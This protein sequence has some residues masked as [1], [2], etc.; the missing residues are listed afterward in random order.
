MPK[1]RKK[2]I[3]IEAVQLVEMVVIKTLEGEMVGE[4]GDWLITG[5]KGEKYPCKDNIFRATYEPVEDDVENTVPPIPTSS[6]T[7]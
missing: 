4:V 1:F 6:F 5:I 2:P 7:F 3:V